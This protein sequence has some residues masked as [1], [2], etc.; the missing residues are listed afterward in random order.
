MLVLKV[1]HNILHGVLLKGLAPMKIACSLTNSKHRNLRITT[2]VNDS[3]CIPVGLGAISYETLKLWQ[4][5]IIPNHNMVE[6]LSKDNFCILV[7]GLKITACNGHDTLICSIIN[8]TSHCGPIG[9]TF[10][11]I[12]QDPGM[13][14]IFVGL[15]LAY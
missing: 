10:D 13:L 4:W 14:K 8:M 1:M 11:M 3:N 9:N 15:Y 7:L 2:T 5:Y 12:K 6:I